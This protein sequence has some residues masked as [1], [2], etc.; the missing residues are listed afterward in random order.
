VA[1]SDQKRVL[2]T[3]AGGVIGSILRAG[4]RGA[5]DLALLSRS[6]LDV[7]AT[8][9]DISKLDEIAAA[10]EG[11]DVVVHLAASDKPESAWEDV[12]PDNIVGTYNVFEAAR[13]AGVKRVVLAS[14]THVVGRYYNDVEPS[15]FELAPADRV[16]ETVAAR[17][18]SLYGVSK[19]F[20][21][22]L[23]RYYHEAFGLAVVCLR[24]GYVRG[25]PDDSFRPVREIPAEWHALAR[26]AHAIW[27]SQR[28]CLELFTRAVEAPID[29]AVVYGTSDNPRQMWDLTSARELLG[30][31]PKDRAPD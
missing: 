4:W 25:G 30:Y 8:V 10:F 12:L 13:R 17:P 18:D 24:I 22:A 31:E 15:G 9:G 11:I 23:A 2:I 7:G 6:P 20:A 21:E 19:V 16:D 5:Y 3:G 1:G 26:R 28:D 29:W 14:S 27:L